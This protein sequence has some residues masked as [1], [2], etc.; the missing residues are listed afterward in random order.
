MIASALVKSAHPKIGSVI[1]FATSSD[2]RIRWLLADSAGAATPAT[3]RLP[4]EWLPV[5]MLAT[6]TIAC[7]LVPAL[8]F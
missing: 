5:A 8:A 2:R 6:L 4:F 1:S 3:S 7:H